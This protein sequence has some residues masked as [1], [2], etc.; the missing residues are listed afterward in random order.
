MVVV[1]VAVA[2]IVSLRSSEM[3]DTLP[4]KIQNEVARLRSRIEETKRL[5]PDNYVSFIVYEM[6]ITESERAVREQ[7]TVAM[8]RL[9]PELEGAD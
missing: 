9:L 8:I 1:V 3:T 6:L 5:F 4:E 2:L 7:D